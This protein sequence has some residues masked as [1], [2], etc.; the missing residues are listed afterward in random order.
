MKEYLKYYGVTYVI[1][2]TVIVVI[3]T[4]YIVD[5]P[6]FAEERIAGRNVVVK[7]TTQADSLGGELPMVK[8]TLSPPVDV[9][10]YMTP[11]PEMV[12][13]G[14]TLFATTCAT[15][16]GNE[17]KGDGIAGVNLNPKPR[18]FHDMN[19][20]TNGPSMTMLYKTLE[21]GITN[22][23]MASYANVPPEDRLNLIAFIRTL[24][25]AFPPIAKVELDSIDIV[26][27]LAKGVKQPNQIPVK[28]AMD[29]ILLQAMPIDK[30]VDSMAAIIK[31]NKTDTGAFI[32]KGISN[33][34]TKALTVLALDSSW[35]SNEA[36]LIKIFDSNPIQNGF[37]PK[38]TY[39]LTKEQLTQLHA[40]L[41]NLFS[42]I[43]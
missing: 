30:K 16:H 19:G 28:M 36:G 33:N 35:N 14:K 1:F 12:E 40:Y 39:M 29:K 15:C 3:G 23:G 22:R 10:K 5:L 21:Q 32:M 11:T 8:G 25:P 2:L 38:A 34:L 13:K 41:R 4:I 9:Y 26:Y 42:Q 6:K 37:K 43:K 31:S 17:G 18:N 27:S 20:W 24:N 7:D